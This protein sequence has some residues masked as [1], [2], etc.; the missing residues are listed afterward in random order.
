M[1][2]TLSLCAGM[3]AGCGSSGDSGSGESDGGTETAE[4]AS[5]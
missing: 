4:T 3:L 1:L 2:L 5:T